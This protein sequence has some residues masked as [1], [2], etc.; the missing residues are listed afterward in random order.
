[1]LK[2]KFRLGMLAAMTA[3]V[4]SPLVSTNAQTELRWSTT[5]SRR[6]GRMSR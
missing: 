2:N 4:I 5:K 6:N 1:M 3:L